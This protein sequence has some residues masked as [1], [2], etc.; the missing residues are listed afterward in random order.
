MTPA[1]K[2]R[3][4]ARDGYFFKIFWLVS[5]SNRDGGSP[6]K[7]TWRESRS[8][9]VDIPLWFNRFFCD[10]EIFQRGPELI[11]IDSVVGGLVYNWQTTSAGLGRIRNIFPLYADF[12]LVKPRFSGDISFFE[13]YL[14]FSSIRVKPRKFGSVSLAHPSWNLQTKSFVCAPFVL[15]PLPRCN[16]LDAVG[17]KICLTRPPRNHPNEPISTV[18]APF[19]LLIP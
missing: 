5:T 4:L 8:S 3:S 7:C 17:L 12:P 10:T 13:N 1:P 6:W 18:C 14:T 2:D 11:S 15:W 19:V 16:I 9:S